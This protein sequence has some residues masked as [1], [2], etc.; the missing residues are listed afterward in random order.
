MNHLTDEQFERLVAAPLPA[1]GREAREHLAV[2]PECGRR[3]AAEARL[4][5]ALRQAVSE[6][7][8]AEASPIEHR[9]RSWLVPIS[10][11][12]GL[13]LLAGVFLVLGRGTEERV[14]VHEPAPLAPSTT[15]RLIETDP[16]MLEAG[17]SVVSPREA[18]L[19]VRIPLGPAA[20]L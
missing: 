14:L 2:C 1:A 15:S 3:L 5:L 4:E 6:V 13:L 19:H 11:A 17:Y 9:R 18:C 10:A 20:R 12:A 16:Y 8:A 7:I